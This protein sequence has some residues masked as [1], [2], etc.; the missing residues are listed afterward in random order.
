M[1]KMRMIDAETRVM[2]NR[3]A[4]QYGNAD[5]GSGWSL[6]GLQE[7]LLTKSDSPNGK[8]IYR[9][10]TQA[11]KVDLNATIAL[12][13]GNGQTMVY[14]PARQNDASN[15]TGIYTY[16]GPKGDFAKLERLP[17]GSYHRTTKDQT[18]YLFDVLDLFKNK[19]ASLR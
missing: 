1:A 14:R 11:P 13:D 4:S 7:L 2:V 17:N 5:F 3:S 12:V 10:R 8:S 15:T 16:V 9:N 19:D 6:V 18:V